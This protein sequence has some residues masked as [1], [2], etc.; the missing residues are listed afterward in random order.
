VFQETDRDGVFESDEQPLANKLVYLY[1]STGTYLAN[2]STNSTGWYQFTA[3]ADG[4]YRVEYDTVAWWDLWNDWA[5][6][7][8][9]SERPRVDVQLSGSARVDFGW[10][11]I[12]RSTDVNSPISTYTA[13]NGLRIRSYDDVVSAQEIW[14]DLTQGSLFGAESPYTV[15][16]FDWGVAEDAVATTVQVDGVYTGFSASITVHYLR[17]L[18]SGD[19]ILFHEYGHA[20][21]D[22]YATIVQQE[23]D[24]PKFTSYLKARGIDPNDPRLDTSHAWT[25]SEMIAEDYRQL[26]GSANAQLRGQENTD[27]P[28]AK[29]VLGL[30]EFLSTTFIQPPRAG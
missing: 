24:F 27:I 5:P 13:P 7:T 23:G 16:N 22:Y 12:T 28:P 4:A 25:P 14:Q 11:P 29:D 6:S 18:D 17:W 26:F 2:A 8:T 21:S 20:W 1:N 3:L 10:R 30:K 19:Q 9:G 15:V